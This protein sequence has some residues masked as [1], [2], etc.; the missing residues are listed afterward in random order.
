[1]L[2]NG[3]TT[4]FDCSAGVSF[5]RHDDFAKFFWFAL[6]S[7]CDEEETG[8]EEEAEGE[9]IGKCVTDVEAISDLIAVAAVPIPIRTTVPTESS[10]SCPTSPS[11]SGTAGANAEH[12][13]R[14]AETQAKP[15]S[16]QEEPNSLQL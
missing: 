13:A 14:R 9:K 12:L 4:E 11:R 16:D 10:S 15:P 6:P 2:P 7:C 1:M 5:A 3:G 8:K